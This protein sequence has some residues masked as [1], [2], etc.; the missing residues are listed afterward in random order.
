[1]SILHSF[2][3]SAPSL[4]HVFPSSLSHPLP[5]PLDLEVFI[6]LQKVLT[7]AQHHLRSVW[8]PISQFCK[9]LQV[10]SRIAKVQ[11][12]CHRAIVHENV[13]G[14]LNYLFSIPPPEILYLKGRKRHRKLNFFKSPLSGFNT[15]GVLFGE[16]WPNGDCTHS[17]FLLISYPSL[18][19]TCQCR[20][21]ADKMVY[22]AHSEHQT[23]MFHG[24]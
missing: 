5:I 9:V 14:W 2:Q 6:V 23:W 24:S 8:N 7:S 21:Q 1:M 17:E 16:T 3:S 22:A 13:R 18:I 10:F 4:L 20:P 11:I 12:H 15:G 19:H